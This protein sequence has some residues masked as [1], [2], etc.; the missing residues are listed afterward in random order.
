[1]IPLLAHDRFIPKDLPAEINALIQCRELQ[2]PI[3]IVLCSDSS[4]SAFT[5]P[6]GCGCAFLGFFHLTDLQV[7]AEDLGPDTDTRNG[8]CTT[9]G[10]NGRVRW[11]FR[12]EWTPGGES[13]CPDPSSNIVRSPWW[14]S[15]DTC[16][17]DPNTASSGH[18]D[19][20]VEMILHPYTL[21]PLHLI[22]AHE[23]SEEQLASSSS[24]VNVSRGWWCASCG[25]MNV[26]Q[27]LR[28]Q[29]CRKC[30]EGNRL[31]PIGVQYVRNQYGV[32]RVSF[33]QDRYADDVECKTR[34]GVD[35]M[36]NYTY[37]M[38]GSAVVRHL[39]TCNLEHAQTEPTLLFKTL[40]ADIEIPWERSIKSKATSS[41]GPVYSY[42]IEGGHA[43]AADI[44]P[45]ANAPECISKAKEL[46]L[47]RARGP[48]GDTL[49]NIQQLTVV[50]WLTSGRKSGCAF[51]A[52]KSP[53]VMLCL[54]AD[55]ELTISPKS[56]KKGRPRYVAE[57]PVTSHLQ[58][59][60]NFEPFGLMD[61]DDE[62]E[63]SNVDRYTHESI[64]SSM[65]NKGGNHG[66]SRSTEEALL[67]TLVHGDILIVAGDEFEYSIKRTG[68]SI[69][70]DI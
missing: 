52:K 70:S 28:Y 60:N 51:Y 22:A 43:G 15:N 8:A 46:L 23:L 29:K 36:R 63:D 3:S 30:K 41:M 11:R 27:C 9:T 13:A 66:K 50:A 54:G 64:S 42:L 69:G 49:V 59:D 1:M 48:H 57:K 45:W 12:F 39:F 55:V 31:L 18:T 34:D 7:H 26:Q 58:D 65:S 53:V 2:M 14:M 61:V 10:R 16:A 37:K 24:E 21:L 44:D 67:V 5:L 25:K 38:H 20:D 47:R 17:N 19:G 56:G 62:V 35:G 32:A 4:L 68:M 40:Q 6:E 33:P